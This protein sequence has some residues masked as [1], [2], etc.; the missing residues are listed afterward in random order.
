[1]FCSLFH[2]QVEYDGLTGHIEFNSKGQRTNYTLKILEKHPGGH[3]QVRGRGGFTLAFSMFKKQEDLWVICELF[4][5]R[6]DV[7][8][9]AL[10]GAASRF[11][12]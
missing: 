9:I 8:F 1:M 5:K 4:V 6:D 3:K 12:H 11:S 2:D 10:I 7:K